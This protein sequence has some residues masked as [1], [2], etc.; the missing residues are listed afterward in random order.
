MKACS[1][2]QIKARSIGKL[3]HVKGVVIRATEVKPML[4]VAT[5]TCDRCGAETYQPISSS[6]FMPIEM[7][8]S[9]DC[10]TNKS[11]GRLCLQTRGSKFVKFQEIKIQEHS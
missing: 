11:G 3:V 5:Y 6:S 10:Q 9:Q 4:Q 7:C 2:R 8:Q 1:V